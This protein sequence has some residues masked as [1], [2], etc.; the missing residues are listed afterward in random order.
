MR[1]DRIRRDLNL[2]LTVLN[3]P[4]CYEEVKQVINRLFYNR[5]QDYSFDKHNDGTFA[6]KNVFA[7]C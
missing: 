1:L 7:R 6:Q 5:N 3:T 4:M 2:V